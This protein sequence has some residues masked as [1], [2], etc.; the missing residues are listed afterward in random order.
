MISHECMLAVWR[1]SCERSFLTWSLEEDCLAHTARS[2]RK[3]GKSPTGPRKKTPLARKIAKPQ[4]CTHGDHGTPLQIIDEPGLTITSSAH[5]SINSCK[6][7]IELVI[8]DYL[9]ITI[10]SEINSSRIPRK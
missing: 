9:Q 8:L 1:S 10:R 3:T 4:A 6:H 5:A 7:K 2:V